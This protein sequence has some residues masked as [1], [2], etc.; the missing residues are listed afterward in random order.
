[1][2]P[3]AI[4]SAKTAEVLVGGERVLPAEAVPELFQ[5]LASTLSSLSG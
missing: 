5:R 1:M 2:Y 4:S 3:R